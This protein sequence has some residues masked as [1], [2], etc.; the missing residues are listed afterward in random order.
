[1]MVMTRGVGPGSLGATCSKDWAGGM[2]IVENFKSFL[3]MA[4]TPPL[5]PSGRGFSM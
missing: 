1:M 2:E 3:K 4:A 5:H